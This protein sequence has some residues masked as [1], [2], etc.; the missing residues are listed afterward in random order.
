VGLATLQ[1]PNAVDKYFGGLATRPPQPIA[2]FGQTLSP[3]IAAA[4]SMDCP[5]DSNGFEC[6]GRGTYV[7]Y[8]E[9]ML[10]LRFQSIRCLCSCDHQTGACRCFSTALLLSYNCEC[11]VRSVVI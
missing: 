9:A 10:E 8:K 3:A 11:P 5:K 1:D 4:L 7:Y 2:E 6:S